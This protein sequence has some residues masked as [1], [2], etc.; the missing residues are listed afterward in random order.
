MK[1]IFLIA[2]LSSYLYSFNDFQLKTLQMVMNK[3][4]EHKAFNKERFPKTLAAICL[5][6]STAGK[7]ESKGKHTIT[8][9][10]KKNRKDIT[11]ASLGVM[12]IRIET[13]KDMIKFYNLKYLK[14]L[15]DKE[16]AERLLND[17]NASTEIATLYFITNFNYYKNFYVAISRYNGGTRNK[18]YVLKVLKNL[19]IINKLVKN[20]SLK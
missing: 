12:Q 9:L 5:S 16:L 6:E 11:K 2:I 7:L 15:S 20:G 8:D 14:N 3:A 18:K 1:K 13:A 19:K 4:R 17:I 10:D